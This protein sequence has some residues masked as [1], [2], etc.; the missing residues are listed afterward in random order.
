[1][2]RAEQETDQQQEEG[3]SSSRKERPQPTAQHVFL[4]HLRV[5][6]VVHLHEFV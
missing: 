5:R 4:V 3:C 2:P 6:K 1:M